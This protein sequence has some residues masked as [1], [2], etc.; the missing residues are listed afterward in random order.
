VHEKTPPRCTLARFWTLGLLLFVCAGGVSI[1]ASGLSRPTTTVTGRV[2]DMTGA[3]L[4]GATVDLLAP[5]GPPMSVVSD[6]RGEFTFQNMPTGR[7]EIVVRLLN[8][9]TWREAISVTNGRKTR[10]TIVLDLALS[11]DVVRRRRSVG[12]RRHVARRL[13]PPLD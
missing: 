5:S 7:H 11:A 8:F 2:L 13:A 1:R 3:V 10:L 6:A 4:P 12:P 9:T